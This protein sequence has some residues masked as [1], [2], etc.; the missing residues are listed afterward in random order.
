MERAYDFHE[1]LH[2]ANT[3]NQLATIKYGENYGLI[4]GRACHKQKKFE[5][6]YIPSKHGRVLLTL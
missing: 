3:L 2:S 1:L 4:F 5:P 6:N